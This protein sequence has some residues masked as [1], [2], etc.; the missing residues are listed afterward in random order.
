MFSFK[1]R[2]SFEQER[3]FTI[4]ADNNVV[5]GSLDWPSPTNDPR[6][7]LIIISFLL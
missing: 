3:G 2:V 5:D 4:A 6:D 7:V 1:F